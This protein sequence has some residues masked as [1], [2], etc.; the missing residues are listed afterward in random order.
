MIKLTHVTDEDNEIPARSAFPKPGKEDTIYYDWD[1][2]GGSYFA[3]LVRVIKYD[4]SGITFQAGNLQDPDKT[5]DN[6]QYSLM[7]TDLENIWWNPPSSLDGWDEKTNNWAILLLSDRFVKHGGVKKELLMARADPG[8]K[9][10]RGAGDKFLAEK[11]GTVVQ[12]LTDF[13]KSPAL[14]RDEE[15][16]SRFMGLFGTVIQ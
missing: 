2:P 1:T 8:N 6:P 11:Y 13:S 9:W 16:Y 3:H 4:G 7:I 5:K 10:P 12:G 14:H 15:L